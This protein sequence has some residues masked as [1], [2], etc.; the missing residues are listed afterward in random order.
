MWRLYLIGVLLSIQALQACFIMDCPNVKRW[1]V[2]KRDGG[3]HQWKYPQVNKFFYKRVKILNICPLN[4]VL[5]HH[6]FF[7]CT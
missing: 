4:L 6:D 7:L 5:F 3:L 2:N 1:A